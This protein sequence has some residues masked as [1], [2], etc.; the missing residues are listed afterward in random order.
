MSFEQQDAMQ[1]E[2]PHVLQTVHFDGDM[3]DRITCDACGA[4]LPLPAP[5]PIK[6]P[7]R[8]LQP[9]KDQLRETI[10]TLEGQVDELRHTIEAMNVETEAARQAFQR[11]WAETRPTG[12]RSWWA[13]LTA[14]IAEWWNRPKQGGLTSFQ[15]H[16]MV[17]AE[18]AMRIAHHRLIE[19]TARTMPR[20]ELRHAIETA[21]RERSQ[22]APDPDHPQGSSADQAQ[23]E[24]APDHDQHSA[25]SGHDPLPVDDRTDPPAH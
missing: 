1:A 13:N 12:L 11:L 18:E 10:K 5:A 9:T 7:R 2:C 6:P 4:E 17:T 24:T 25:E 20:E 21:H 19:R 22:V 15:I 16:D 8:M 3:I 14:G 23:A